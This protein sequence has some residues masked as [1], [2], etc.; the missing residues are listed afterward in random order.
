MVTRIV[1][2]ISPKAESP[3]PAPA[4]NAPSEAAI[5]TVES[6]KKEKPKPQLCNH[7]SCTRRAQHP[8]PL[9]WRHGAQDVEC[10]F[11]GCDKRG[12][13]SGLCPDHG[14]L[15]QLCRWRG[16]INKANLEK[17]GGLCWMHRSRGKHDDESSSSEEEEVDIR[18]CSYR[19]CISVATADEGI[20]D[21]HSWLKRENN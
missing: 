12:I 18:L 3:P 21:R 17:R 6:E 13:L 10:K 16:C 2:R 14:G 9:C 5:V 4:A 11:S 19:G 20:C 7:A 15:V 1:I 8:S